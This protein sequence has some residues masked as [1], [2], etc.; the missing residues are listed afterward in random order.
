MATPTYDQVRPYSG[1][2]PVLKHRTQKCPL[3]D[4]EGRFLANHTKNEHRS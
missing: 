4:W 2:P 3:C 1:R